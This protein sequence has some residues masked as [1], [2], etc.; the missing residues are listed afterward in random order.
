MSQP[1][2]LASVLSHPE[3]QPSNLAGLVTTI[4][5][6]NAI[7]DLTSWINDEGQPELMAVRDSYADM[8]RASLR[9]Q[10]AAG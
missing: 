10:Q 1:D 9:D 4:A 2:R 8:L 5:R 7:I 3:P 6:L